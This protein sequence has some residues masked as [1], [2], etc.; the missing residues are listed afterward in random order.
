MSHHM[1]IS[2][3]IDNAL[4]GAPEIDCHTD[5]IEMRF[6]TKRRFTGKIYVQ[7]HYSNSDC[8][9]DY[10]QTNEAGNPIGGIKLHHGSCDMDRQRII[11]PEGMQFSTVLVISFHP[12]FITKTDRAFH[13]NC[14]YREAVRSVNA[15]L[16]VSPIP[17]ETVAY[18]MPMP[19]C[20]YTI[21]KDSLDGPV[22][23][24]AKVGDLVVHK[25]ECL[26]DA[27][28]Y[29]MLVHSCFVED[30]QGEK[31]MVIDERGCHVDRIVLGDPTYTEA[32]N[33]AYRESYVF[34]FADRVGVRFACEIKLC[35]K[36]DGGC[37]SIVPPICGG[38]YQ[39]DS[40]QHYLDGSIAPSQN[41]S[42]GAWP[43]TLVDQTTTHNNI[44]KRRAP[45]HNNQ[46]ISALAT[47]D[48]ISQ[49]V[50]VLDAID[51]S[52]E[53]ERLE[54]TQDLSSSAVT[55][56]HNYGTPICLS[57]FMLA[58]IIFTI[59]IAFAFITAVVLHILMKHFKTKDV[60]ADTVQP[61]SSPNF[62]FK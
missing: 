41:E 4:L 45:R 24:Y 19:D 6:R 42:N 35:V 26:S 34:K 29:G 40:D 1:V 23:K 54:K 56:N 30:G 37:A 32:L 27:N 53:A 62:I 57:S 48:L 59:A 43:T 61:R 10:S 22:L 49:Y 12:L 46:N 47:A 33:M 36:E 3:E 7:G 14:L 38:E 11:Q 2:L 20:R 55:A 16:T 25:W 39:K 13:I 51:G 18:D 8:R 52:N 17:S 9:V 5:T 15:G 44:V 50:Y 58:T 21:H 28:M 31:R 60:P